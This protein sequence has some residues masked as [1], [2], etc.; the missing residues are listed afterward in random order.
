MYKL[1]IDIETEN[2]IDELKKLSLADLI[3][4][5]FPIDEYPF[6]S[7]STSITSGDPNK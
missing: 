4:S 6:L 2:E 5:C 7:V 1:R 3:E